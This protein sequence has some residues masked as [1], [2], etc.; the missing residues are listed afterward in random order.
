MVNR[1]MFHVLLYL[2]KLQGRC[3]ARY[4][5]SQTE[6]VC[7]VGLD[8]GNVSISYAWPETAWN[9]VSL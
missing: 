5:M 4:F 1:K 2:C 8:G 3:C 6:R 9:C 7:S